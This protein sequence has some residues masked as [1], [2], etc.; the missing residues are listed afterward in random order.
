MKRVWRVVFGF[1][2]GFLLA[3]AGPS[4]CAEK[5]SDLPG[6]MTWSAYDVGSRGYVQGAW[7]MIMEEAMVK[8]IPGK[9]F[10]EF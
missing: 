4:P 3:L 10:S 2:L 6:M 9:D 8:K 1:S 5:G 7:K